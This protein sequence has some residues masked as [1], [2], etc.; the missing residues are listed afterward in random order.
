MFSENEIRNITFQVLSGLVFVHKH[1]KK[2]ASLFGCVNS[3]ATL[4]WSMYQE[5]RIAIN[6]ANDLAI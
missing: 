6:L 1:G 2:E 4:Q 5:F 3:S